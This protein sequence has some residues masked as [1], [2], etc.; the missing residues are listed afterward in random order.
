[1]ED[2]DILIDIQIKRQMIVDA[3]LSGKIDE[4]EPEMLTLA[5]RA[6]SDMDRTVT[7]KARIQQGKTDGDSMAGQVDLLTELLK[8]HKAIQTTPSI[9]KLIDLP[10]QN[11]KVIDGELD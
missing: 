11:I 6:M 8:Q 1:M 2:K 3:I 9:R 7:N 5:L 10:K 4:L